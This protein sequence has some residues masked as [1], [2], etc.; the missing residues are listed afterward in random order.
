[1]ITRLVGVGQ[2]K[3]LLIFQ[4]AMDDLHTEQVL[5][6][7]IASPYLGRAAECTFTSSVA[8]SYLVL[9]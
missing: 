2:E 6:L 8:K 7:G 1:M 4:V 3:E 9:L 5:S